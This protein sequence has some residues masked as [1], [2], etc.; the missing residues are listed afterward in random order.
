MSYKIHD[1]PHLTAYNISVIIQ[2]DPKVLL[3]V[4]RALG[5]FL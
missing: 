2:P 5:F 1:L 4:R 3:P